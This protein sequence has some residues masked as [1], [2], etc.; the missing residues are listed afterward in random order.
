MYVFVM[1]KM[2]PLSTHDLLFN[3]VGYTEVVAQISSVSA[4]LTDFQL[5]TC[6]YFVFLLLQSSV[7]HLRGLDE[8]QLLAVKEEALEMGGYFICNGNE[9]VIRLLIMP[10]RN[11]V[12]SLPQFVVE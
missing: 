9:R 12:Y 8:R 3:S 11:H 10:K 2:F 6:F 5:Q 1:G 4:A 7:C